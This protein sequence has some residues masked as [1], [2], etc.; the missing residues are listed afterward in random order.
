LPSKIGW[1]EEAGVVPVVPVVVDLLVL[2]MSTG[3]DGSLQCISGLQLQKKQ[4]ESGE[5]LNF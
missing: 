1:S 2:P 5:K 4:G 3:A